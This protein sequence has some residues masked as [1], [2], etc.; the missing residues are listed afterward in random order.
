MGIQPS[1]VLLGWGCSA[2]CASDSQR[3]SEADHCLSLQ[4]YF[5]SD[6]KALSHWAENKLDKCDFLHVISEEKEPQ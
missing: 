1:L 2:A 6:V 3:F 4:N 5:R